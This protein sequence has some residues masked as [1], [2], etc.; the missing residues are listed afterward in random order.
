[1]IEAIGGVCFIAGFVLLFS[2][3][4]LIVVWHRRRL[5]RQLAVMLTVAVISVNAA[6][7]I[8]FLSSVRMCFLRE[9]YHHNLKIY[10]GS[11][12]TLD[13]ARLS[14]LTREMKEQ[15]RQMLPL[16]WQEKR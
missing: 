11:V 16:Q 1:M 2:A 4:P 8:S 9:F 5:T 13:D 10:A 14:E 7:I 12:Q 3:L 15:P 6:W